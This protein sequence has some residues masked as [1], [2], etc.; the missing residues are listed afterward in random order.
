MRLIKVFDK[1]FLILMTIQG[2]ITIFIDSRK[3]NTFSM[4][5]AARKAKKIGLSCIIIS[6]ALYMIN[7]FIL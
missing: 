1:Y 7:R 5:D 3:F 2:F 6:A 4:K